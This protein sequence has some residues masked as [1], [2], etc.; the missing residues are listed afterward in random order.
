MGRAPGNGVRR[1]LDLTRSEFQSLNHSKY[2]LDTAN[3]TMIAVERLLAAGALPV[4][5]AIAT[6][7]QAQ[8]EIYRATLRN[9]QVAQ[10][11]WELDQLRIMK[12]DGYQGGEAT[13]LIL[14]LV[15][16]TQLGF[17][18]DI[19]R[20][21]VALTQAKDGL[22]V[23]GD[24]KVINKGHKMLG[25]TTPPLIQLSDDFKRGKQVTWVQAKSEDATSNSITGLLFAQPPSQPTNTA[26]SPEP[27]SMDYEL[28]PENETS[29]EGDAE[30]EVRLGWDRVLYRR[31]M[32]R[33]Q[34]TN[35]LSRASLPY[36][37]AATAAISAWAIPTKS[38]CE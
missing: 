36:R 21:N 32:A 3:V 25:R 20:L 31:E 27:A 10:L 2:N 33:T 6:P 28:T 30:L 15:V 35:P 19:N 12:I 18:Q 8:Y 9:L 22:I 37:S 38:L 13:Y 5:M 4:D 24:V 29:R 7:Y 17:I 14:D 23:V 34:R 26:D 1:F 16:T 11:R